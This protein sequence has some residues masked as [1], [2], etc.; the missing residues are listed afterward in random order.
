V[1]VEEITYFL[2]W[3]TEQDVGEARAYEQRRLL[4]LSIPVPT[5]KMQQTSLRQTTTT[6][7]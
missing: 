3:E 1:R 7:T 2:P 6:N 4:L 5:T